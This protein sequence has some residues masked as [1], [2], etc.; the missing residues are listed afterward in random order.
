[1]EAKQL[2]FEEIEDL[3]RAV[4][5][6]ILELPEDDAKTVRMPHG[7]VTEGASPGFLKTDDV[8]FIYVIP[9]DDGYGQQYHRRYVPSEE[10]PDMLTQVSEHTDIYNIRFTIYG[11]KSHDWVRKIKDTLYRDDI[12]KLLRESGFFIKAGIPPPVHAPEL[13]EGSWWRRF[14]L[15]TMFYQFVRQVYDGEIAPFEKVEINITHKPGARE[16]KE[17]AL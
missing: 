15:T 6:K 8:C 16:E 11:P 10:N 17:G 12:K 7:S 3:F 2:S 14:D 13:H 4:V 9:T 5:L 1:M